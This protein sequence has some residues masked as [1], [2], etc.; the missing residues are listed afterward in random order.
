MFGR[1]FHDP[2][3]SFFE[4]PWDG[5]YWGR[6][7][8]FSRS[9]YDCLILWDDELDDEIEVVEKIRRFMNG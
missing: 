3:K 6:L 9:G 8:R 4:V 1:V 2:E 5:Q 7:A